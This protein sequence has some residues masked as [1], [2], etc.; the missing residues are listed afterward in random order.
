MWDCEK[1]QYNL[2]KNFVCKGSISLK[3]P[4]LLSCNENAETM[5]SGM[6]SLHLTY[7]IMTSHVSIPIFE[8][9]GNQTK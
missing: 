5:E 2:L 4:S 8:V 3:F 1:I 9:F 7:K 6:D